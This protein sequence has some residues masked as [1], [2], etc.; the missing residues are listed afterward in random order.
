MNKY[1]YIK[2]VL[3]TEGIQIEVIGSNKILLVF[4]W[5]YRYVS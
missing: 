2:Y 4:D 3:F 5:E 1:T